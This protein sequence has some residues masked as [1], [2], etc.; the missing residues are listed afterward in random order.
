MKKI[1]TFIILSFSVF[2]IDAV[3]QE[4]IETDYT[5]FIEMVIQKNREYQVQQLDVLDY[6]AGVKAAGVRAD[7]ELEVSYLENR[8]NKLRKGPGFEGQLSWDLEFGGKRKARIN[9][10]R[11]QYR[12]SREILKGAEENLKMEA[13]IAYL[14]SVLA[15]QAFSVIEKAYQSMSRIAAFDSIRHQLGE[16][17]KMEAQQSRLEA[18]LAYNEFKEAKL[19]WQNKLINLQSLI[20]NTSDTLYTPVYSINIDFPDFDFDFWYQQALNNKSDL[21]VAEQERKWMEAEAHAVR[22]DRR[23]DLVLFAGVEHNKTSVTPALDSPAETIFNIG[24]SFPLKF[25]NN[26]KAALY[27][28]DIAIKQADIHLEHTRSELYNGLKE[29]Y[30][31]FRKYKEMMQTIQE[32]WLTEAEEMLKASNYAYER[33]STT[34]LQV[35]HAQRANQE[36]QLQFLDTKAAYIEALLSL[37]YL[38]N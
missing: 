26:N 21:Y 35:L 36:I 28:A 6:E 22:A 37:Q 17:P 11:E 15:E 1:L 10:A 12:W 20:G 29:Q 33:G 24:F 30:A 4:T 5:S 16:I 32:E 18:N 13:S 7:P 9:V 2:S 3:A 25:S 27:Q 23:M 14:E 31:T 19:N 38:S 34:F 8:E